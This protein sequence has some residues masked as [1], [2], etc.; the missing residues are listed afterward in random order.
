MNNYFVEWRIN[1]SARSA[2]E[3]AEKALAIQRDATSIATVFN[4]TDECGDEVQIDL[5]EEG[6][7]E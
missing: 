7:E 6:D 2:H 5:L 3:A 1:I 4:I